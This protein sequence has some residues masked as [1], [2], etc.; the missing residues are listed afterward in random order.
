MKL[1]ENAAVIRTKIG[2]LKSLINHG[3][4]HEA[5]LVLEEIA[6]ITSDEV[7]NLYNI[8]DALILHVN[9]H[10][11]W[12]QMFKFRQSVTLKNRLRSLGIAFLDCGTTEEDKQNDKHCS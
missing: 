5:L 2:T 10:S 6:K 1:S 7:I 3:E 9:N 4:R 11:K 8:A 12:A